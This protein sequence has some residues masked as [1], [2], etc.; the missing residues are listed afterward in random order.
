MHIAH[1]YGYL[2]I[3]VLFFEMQNR[4]LKIIGSDAMITL[5][6]KRQRQPEFLHEKGNREKMPRIHLFLSNVI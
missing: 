2:S 6:E 3:Y 5:I 1:V 4:R